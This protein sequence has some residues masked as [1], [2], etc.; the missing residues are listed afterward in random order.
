MAAALEVK[1]SGSFGE[2]TIQKVRNDFGRLREA[3][4]GIEKMKHTAVV[5]Q[6][7]VALPKRLQWRRLDVQSM[8]AKMAK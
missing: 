6:K 8:L 2:A 3:G 4:V 7:S 5:R 1:N